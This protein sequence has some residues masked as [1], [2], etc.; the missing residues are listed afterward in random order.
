MGISH[1]VNLKM[2][3]KQIEKLIQLVN[4]IKT[5]IRYT[6]AEIYDIVNDLLSNNNFK[7]LSFLNDVKNNMNSMPF[8]TAWETAITNWNSSILKEDEELLSSMANILGASDSTGQI[9]ALDH[10]EKRFETSYEFAKNLCETKGKLC[11]SL[12]ILMGLAVLVIFI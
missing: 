8:P 3:Q 10:I 2:N 5:E 4:W 11:K 9:S 7:S 6:Q 1:C 12:G